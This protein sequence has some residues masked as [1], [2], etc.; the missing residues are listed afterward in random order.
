MNVFV[1]DKAVWFIDTQSKVLQK[2]FSFET[3][4]LDIRQNNDQ[5]AIK[6]LK[7][8]DEGDFQFIVYGYMNRG[9]HEGQAGIGLYTYSADKNEVREDVFI[10]SYLPFQ[11]LKNSIGN[12]CYLN[13]SGILYIMLDEFVYALDSHANKATLFVSGL[14]EN[15]FKSSAAGRMLAWQDGGESNTA[16]RINVVDL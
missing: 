8:T 9:M 11:M 3:S 15:N 10:P 12:L 4:P 1:A 5:H 2:V 6:L 7:I 14:N 16:V 13:N